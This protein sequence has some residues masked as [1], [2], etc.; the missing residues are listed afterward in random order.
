MSIQG[1]SGAA[2]HGAPDPSVGGGIAAGGFA[3]RGLADGSIRMREDVADGLMQRPPKL[4]PKYFYD[5]A[6]A[7]LFEQITELDAYYLTRTEIGILERHLGDIAGHVGPEAR[8]VEFGSG[9]GRKTRALLRALDRPAAY[10]PIDVAREQLHDVATSLR[11]EFPALHVHPVCADYT[12]E[13]Q[14]PALPVGFR[15]T[16]AFFPGSTIGNFEP[17]HALRF[18]RRVRRLVGPDGGLLVGTDMHKD[19]AVLERA[20][21][22]PE[23]VTAAFNLNLLHR[24]NRECGT[25]FDVSAFR[26]HAIYDEA[27]R[28]IEMRLV[29]ERDV[30]ITVPATPRRASQRIDMRAGEFIITEYSHKFTPDG[31]E[32]LAG[33]AGWHVARTWQDDAGAFCIWLLRPDRE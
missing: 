16:L 24:L 18:L 5:D 19:T 30:V 10:T 32:A 13:L 22:D 26:H 7:R 11:R 31:F 27:N 8:V 33:E 4:A 6:G 1:R 17:L 15:G 12:A 29:C 2:A 20:Y 3:A 25:D 23:G 28:R 14:L 9:S 21:N